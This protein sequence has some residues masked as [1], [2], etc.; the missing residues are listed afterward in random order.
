[1]IVKVRTTVGIKKAGEHQHIKSHVREGKQKWEI[2]FW[3]VGWGVG[4]G[5]GQG[6]EDNKGTCQKSMRQ[7][8]NVANW[9]FGVISDIINIHVYHKNYPINHQ[10]IWSLPTSY[11]A[12]P[13]WDCAIVHC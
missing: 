9:T 7:Y 13:L 12:L 11:P 4:L 1:M 8:F 6:L 10:Y 3:G 2:N 5:L